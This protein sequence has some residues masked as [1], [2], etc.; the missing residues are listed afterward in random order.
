MFRLLAALLLLVAPFPALAGT[1]ETEPST[2]AVAQAPAPAGCTRTARCEVRLTAPQLLAS[3]ERLVQAGR[4]P[5]ARALL[6]AL[7][8]APGFTMQT[9]FLTG[10]MAAQEGDLATAAREYKAILADDPNQT[11]VRLELGRTMIAMGQSAAADRQLRLAQQSRELDPDLARLVRGARDVIRS[12]RAFRADVSLALAPDTNIN[13]ATDARTVDVHLGDYSLPLELDAGARRRSG[14]GQTATASAA[15]RLPVGGDLFFLG[16]LDVSALNYA[17]TRFDDD[18]VQAAA[19]GEAQLSN[20]ASVSAQMIG[21]QRWYGGRVA[22]RQI[23]VRG[24]GQW[25]LDATRRFGLQVDVRRTDTTFDRA[26]DGW[27]GGLYLSYETSFRRT[28]VAAGQAFVRR[29]WLNAKA[30]SN[31][32]FGIGASVAGEL[33]RGFNV[34]FGGSVSRARFDAAIPIFSLQPRRDWRVTSQVTIGN[35]KL[36]VLGFS[37]QLSWAATGILSSL[38]LYRTKR[39]RFSIGLARYF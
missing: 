21:A 29:D 31:T 37:P 3:A 7:R 2:A 33:P 36:R 23:G 14:T 25:S 34:G 28:F 15:A 16:N 10:F 32:E 39:S 6:T 22:S 13:N 19:G 30:Y 17:G 18:L 11:R 4:Y 26:F 8:L 27:Q 20:D 24:G 35:R 9:R 1:V 38:D 12:A 5:E